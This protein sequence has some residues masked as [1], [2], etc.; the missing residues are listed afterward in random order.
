MV[1]YAGL[2]PVLQATAL[3]GS[4]AAMAQAAPGGGRR[5][6]QIA[7]HLQNDGHVDNA[8]RVPALLGKAEAVILSMTADSAYDG[9]PTCAT[10]AARQRQPAPDVVVPPRASTV[11]S[12]DT[13]DGDVQSPRD[14]IRPAQSS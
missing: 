6:G 7:A 12:V 9:Q 11:P 14:R 5:H 10:A 3:G 4:P 8:V 1:G 13:D 2:Q